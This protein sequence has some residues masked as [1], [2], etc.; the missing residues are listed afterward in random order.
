MSIVQA[1]LKRGRSSGFGIN[2]IS[3]ETKHSDAIVDCMSSCNSEQRKG[4]SGNNE[5]YDIGGKAEKFEEVVQFNISTLQGPAES[6]NYHT[7]VL[8]Q[9]Y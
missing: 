3:L 7:L 6:S 1:G 8:F 2:P 5:H 4:F 9:S